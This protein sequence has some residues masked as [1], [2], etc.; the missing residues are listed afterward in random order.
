MSAPSSNNLFDPRA[1]LD[2]LLRHAD[3]CMTI[4]RRRF[5][6]RLLGLA[7]ARHANRETPGVLDRIR[8]DIDRSIQRR[9]QRA[10][11]LPRPTFPPDLPISDKRDLIIDALKTHQVIV[12]CGET[13]SGKSTQLPKICLSLGRGVA[14]MIAHT[15]PRRIAARAVATRV[16]EELGTPLG[17]HV[18][19]KVRFGDQTSPSTNIKVMTDGVLLAEI[20]SDPLLEQ[21]DTIIIDEAHERSLNIDFLLGS[22]KQLLPKRPDLKLIITS[23]TIDPER[24]SKHFDNAPIVMVSGRAYP[25]DI[26]YRPVTGKDDDELEDSMEHAIVSAVA[27]LAHDTEGD[28]LIFLA[29]EREIRESMDLLEEAGWG[30]HAEI[31]PLFARLST[32]DQMRVFQPGKRRRLVLATNVAETS[33][34]VP[35]VRG[36][37]DCGFARISRYSPKTKVQRLPIEAISQASANQRAGRCGRVG[38]GICIRLYSEQDFN[39]RPPFTAPE[40]LRTNLASV[41]LRLKGL[42]LGDARNFPFVEPPEDRM[43]ADAEDTLVQLCALTDSG[44]K[45]ELTPIGTLMARLPVEPWAARIILWAR[46]DELRAAHARRRAAATDSNKPTRAMVGVLEEILVIV[47]G[48]SIMDPRERPPELQQKADILHARFKDED[49]D[50]VSMLRLWRYSKDQS[51]RLSGSRMRRLCRDEFLSFVR[52]R[53]WDEVHRQLKDMIAEL[54]GGSLGISS[55]RDDDARRR[56]VMDQ[57][58]PRDT[59]RRELGGPTPTYEAIHRALLTGMLTGILHKGETYEYDGVRGTKASI[60]PGSALFKINPQWIVAAELVRT[61]RLFARTVAKVKPE[62]IEEAGQHMLKSSYSDPHY[63]ERT[64]R[65]MAWQRV[66]LLGL[67]IVERRRAHFGPVDPALSREI[68]AENALAEGK[69]PTPGRFM[70]H[71]MELLRKAIE[72]RHKL[73]RDDALSD[74]SQRA[75]FFLD[76]IAPDVFTG[77]AFERWREQAER[78]TPRILFMDWPDLITLPAGFDAAKSFPD[79]ITIGRANLKLEYLFDTASDADGVT[80]IVPIELVSALD[81]R[82]GQWLVP[83]MLAEKI[84]CLI[85]S[86]PKRLRVAFTPAEPAAREIAARLHEPDRPLLDALAQELSSIARVDVLASDFNAVELPAHLL[87]NYRVIDRAGKPLAQGRDLRELRR[88]L[89]ARVSHALQDTI[90]S[91]W[92]CSRVDNWTFPDIPDRVDVNVQGSLM[93][94]YPA[95]AV[96]H[97]SCACLRLYASPAEARRAHRRGQV[98]LFMSAVAAELKHALSHIKGFNQLALLYS[99][100]GKPDQLRAAIGERA[101][102]LTFVRD[103][104]LVTMGADFRHRLKP[105]EPWIDDQVK[106]TADLI[107]EILT[108]R[109]HIALAL[110][111]LHEPAFAPTRE[112]ATDQ[113]TRLL[114]EYWLTATPMVWFTQYPRYLQALHRRLARL[115]QQGT[116][117]AS[118]DIRAMQDVRTR[119]DELFI[120]QDDLTP[121]DPRHE[122]A[123]YYRWMLEEHRVSIFAQ[124]LGTKFPASPSKLDELW[125]ALTA[126]DH[127]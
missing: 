62:W 40:I 101:C 56:K 73:R 77:P 53:E 58:A 108:Q 79:T 124:D 8:R 7:R 86:L 38:P 63:D 103:G 54:P 18:G 78:T 119:E 113:L 100:L 50:F 118:K 121:D 94:A 96:S 21:Y 46:E 22:I 14:G 106:V 120:L 116:A 43:I 59:H 114:P 76:R 110:N 55:T 66:T 29:S 105:A 104:S 115:R 70:S 80:A 26:R 17:Q 81:H 5:R 109:Q 67:T 20:Q 117:A 126:V 6:Q 99:P 33:I 122:A 15:Q 91:P 88:R 25:V 93:W 125:R 123:E 42:R 23:A 64:A 13:G 75:A 16:A 19:F 34:T 11:S 44:E 51:A 60:F 47:A 57:L 49:S 98:R 85:R 92:N 69:L 82:P 95:I 90:D 35:G 9:R 112:D 4:D 28:I 10:A 52:L 84:E 97:D 32:A 45:G 24:F 1:S 72:L 87:M 107:L 36:V 12:V 2:D 102:E 48:L 27:E 31:V 111:A 37:I 71:N 61:S 74:P 41:V 39:S 83:G 89:I 30:K 68:F 127:G 3:R 65:V